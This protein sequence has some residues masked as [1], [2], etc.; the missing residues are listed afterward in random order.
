MLSDGEWARVAG[1]VMHRTGLAPYGQEDDSVRWV[2]VRHAD[3]HIHLVA[4]LARQ[5]GRQ[6]DLWHDY[7]RVRE[8]CQAAEERYDLRRT[9]PADRTAA[10]R[11]T[12]SESEKADRKRW[13]ETARVTLRREVSTA[14]A[15]ATDERDFF[16]RLQHAGVLVRT[17]SSARN[18]GEITGYAVALPADTT[19]AGEPV[20]YSGGKLPPT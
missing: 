16:A 4:M 6:P 19:P 14:A 13:A 10:H 15:A 20:W 7:F 2:A 11:P 3:D 12:R 5:D 1:D 9:A 8:A 18:P 17:R